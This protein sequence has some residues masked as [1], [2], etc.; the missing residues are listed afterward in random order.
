M[1]RGRK[2]KRDTEGDKD[3]ARSNAPVRTRAAVASGSSQNHDP[4]PISTPNS[5]APEIELVQLAGAEDTTEQDGN[6]FA[7]FLGN[8]QPTNPTVPN[9]EFTLPPSV[10][11]CIEDDIMCHVSSDL[12]QKIWNRQFI[13]LSS[14]LRN[15]E[16][17]SERGG[18]LVV[19]EQG[20]IEVKKS[21][22][23]TVANIREW[24]DAFL[25]FM[26][27]HLRKFKEDSQELI[28]YM[29]IIREA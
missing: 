4:V 14:L 27:I 3:R 23:R 8:L 2:R 6:V 10:V 24:T 9:D 7:S 22:A 28:Q 11:G 16:P 26:S 17:N 21:S 18:N 1:P 25:V 29:V 12:R 20:E 15:N 13:N 5:S 19:N